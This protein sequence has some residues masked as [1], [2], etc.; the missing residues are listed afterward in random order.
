[1]QNF[2]YPLLSDTEGT[3]A[4]QLSYRWKVSGGALDR[5]DADTVR[6]TPPAQGPHLAGRQVRRRELLRRKA[7]AP[8]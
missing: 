2:D 3:V 8:Q 7:R 4:T 1:M 6:W 5:S